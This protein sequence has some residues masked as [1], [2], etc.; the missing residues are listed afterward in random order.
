MRT[1]EWLVSLKYQEWTSTNHCEDEIEK[2]CMR[3]DLP[4][5]D[6]L[7]IDFVIG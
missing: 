2:E 5:D 3:D 4:E 6:G 1:I 7:E